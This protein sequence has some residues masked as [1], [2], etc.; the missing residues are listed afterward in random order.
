MG[1][2][3]LAALLAVYPSYYVGRRAPPYCAYQGGYEGLKV[4]CIDVLSSAYSRLYSLSLDML[5]TLWSSLDICVSLVMCLSPWALVRRAA[6]A[7]SV[8]W[9]SIGAAFVP[10]L[11]YLEVFRIR[12]IRVY[13]TTTHVMILA[14]FW[15]VL[16]ESVS[17]G[18]SLRALLVGTRSM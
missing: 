16:Y 15:V 14:N 3:P 5:A 18:S 1:R 7:A 4:N 12:A 17:R 2:A 11:V 10:Y 6:H 13:C 8:A 9:S